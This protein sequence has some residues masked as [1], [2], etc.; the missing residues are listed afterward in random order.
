MPKKLA[1]R[2]LLALAPAV[3][4]CAGQ[5]GSFDSVSALRTEYARHVGPQAAAVIEVPF[6]LDDEIRRVLA[7]TVPPEGTDKRRINRL[8]D[9][10]FNDVELRYSLVPTRNAVETYRA[11]EGNCLSF[12]NLFVGAAREQRLAPFYVEVVDHQRWN[13]RD[14]M[15][16]SQGHIVAGVYIDGR[17]QTYDFLPYRAKSYRDFK[18]IDDV[19]ASAHYFNNLGAEALM[20][21]DTE[22]AHRLI[23]IATKI[24]PDFVKAIN[25]LGVSLARRGEIDR[26]LETYRRG[27]EIEPDNVAL[28]TNT[29][30]LYQQRGNADQ[31]AEVLAKI[32]DANTTNPFFYVYQGEAALARGD[33][34]AAL[35]YMAEALRRDSEIPEVHL[36]LAKVYLALGQ[37]EKARHH[38]ERTLKLDA[39]NAEAR[40]LAGLLAT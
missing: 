12:V 8:V 38:I 13:H 18:P 19:T 31:A 30:R 34:K 11:R 5:P 36:G 7:G 33:A 16:I 1:Q 3:A 32:E 22:R 6:E 25:N 26:A 15:V 2:I 20:A 27:L 10:V 37:V 29:A 40:R 24:A 39:T 21:G 23:E 4:G 9:F 17:L 28:L 35:E 14:G